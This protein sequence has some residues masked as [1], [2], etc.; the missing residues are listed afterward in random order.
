MK[1]SARASHDPFDIAPGR[2]R[3]LGGHRD[4][5][6]I[7]GGVPYF[8]ADAPLAPPGAGQ[9]LG[10]EAARHRHPGEGHRG[11]SG[12]GTRFRAATGSA[13]ASSLSC[14][15]AAWTASISAPGLN[16]P[17]TFAIKV[18]TGLSCQ[19]HTFPDLVIHHRDSRE[20]LTVDKELSS[21]VRRQALS[22]QLG[23]AVFHKVKVESVSIRLPPSKSP[24]GASRTGSSRINP[25]GQTIAALKSH[26]ATCDP[27]CK[28]RGLQTRSMG[29]PHGFVN[30]GFP[31]ARDAFAA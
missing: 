1:G 17:C 12:V 26:W 8:P 25:I 9:E 23:G 14:L 5:A 30:I 2:G 21:Q 18:E 29:Q 15:R 13:W 16:E 7:E 27:A 24:A 10:E 28:P 22:I 3:G 19:I 6:R 4:A 11:P 31:A 20:Q